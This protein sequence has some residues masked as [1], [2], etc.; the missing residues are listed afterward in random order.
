MEPT[1]W[2]CQAAYLSFWPRSLDHYIL[3][4]W[5]EM[6]SVAS[7]SFCGS[8]G[9]RKYVCGWCTRLR[10]FRRAKRREHSL[11]TEARGR[12]GRLRPRGRRSFAVATGAVRRF[13]KLPSTLL[14]KWDD[15]APL[16]ECDGGFFADQ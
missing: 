6:R 11:L 1:R 2:A 16:R 13:E 12:D 7:N 9:K 14:G 10:V 4:R 3:G 15:G 5:I 8:D